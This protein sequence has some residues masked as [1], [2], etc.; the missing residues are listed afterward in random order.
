MFLV[1]YA[2]STTVMVEWLTLLFR[3]WEVPG[4]DF[5]YPE[6]FSGFTQSLQANVG[7]IPQIKPRPLSSTSFPMH[8]SLILSSDTI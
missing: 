5:G 6:L 3:I 8:L 4:S 1:A 7:I 2:N